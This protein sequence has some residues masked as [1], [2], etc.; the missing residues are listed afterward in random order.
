[1]GEVM[2]GYRKK[3]KNSDWRRK[4]RFSSASRNRRGRQ[5]KAGIGLALA[6]AGV[7]LIIQL[8]PISFWYGILLILVCALLY[9][10][11]FIK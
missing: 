9:N 5:A 1:M 7:I 4:K 2:N 3:R 8:I 10:A 6:V 11:F